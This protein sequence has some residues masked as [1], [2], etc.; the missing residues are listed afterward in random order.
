MCSERDAE[1]ALGVRDLLVRSPNRIQIAERRPD[2]EQRWM[3]FVRNHAKAI[4]ACDFLVVVTAGRSI[5]PLQV[6]PTVYE[7]PFGRVY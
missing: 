3:T 5:G 6:V 7:S 2:L 4:V 1:A